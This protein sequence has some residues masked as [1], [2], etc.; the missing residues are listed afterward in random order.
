MVWRKCL[1]EKTNLE[2]NK[3][4]GKLELFSNVKARRAI[5]SIELNL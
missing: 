1:G 3:G 4:K 2:P 5:V